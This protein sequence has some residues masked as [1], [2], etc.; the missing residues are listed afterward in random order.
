MDGERVDAS[1]YTEAKLSKVSVELLQDIDKETVKFIPNFDNSLKEPVI[2]PGKVP[3]LLINGSSGI[4]VGMTTNIPPHNLNEICDGIISAINKPNITTD[5][6][7]EIV[8]GPD[9][10]TGG[11][12][13]AENL[14]E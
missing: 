1:R 7:M 14:K 10:P 2:L 3:N 5:E 8:Q 12:I 13:V 6:L 11:Q 9:F 4:A